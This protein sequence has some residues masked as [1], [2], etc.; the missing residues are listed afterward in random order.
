MTNYE[1]L[2]DTLREAFMLDKA[3]LDFG[4]Y[5]IM[6][7]KRKD[8]EQFLEKDL[9][10]Q[11]REIL[12]SNSAVDVVQLEREIQQEIDTA[13]KYGNPN[14]EQLPVVQELREKYEQANNMTE[15]ENEVFSLLSN[16]FKRYF[17]KGD[18]ISMR[19]Y[20]KDVYAIPYEG[21]EVKLHWANADQYYI[22]SSENFKIYRFK[23]SNGKSVVFELLEATTEQNNNKS[24]GDKERK[25]AI[26]AENPCEVVDEEFK[27]YFNYEPMDKKVKQDDL[28]K[29]A[30]SVVKDKIPAD[31]TELLSLRPTEKDKQRTLL[32]KNLTDYTA[33]NTFDYFIHKDLNGFLTR[34]L[35]FYIKNEVLF[36]D[37]INTRDEQA[38]VRQ[39]SKIKA[40]KNIG[41]K[42][43]TFLAQLEDFQKKLWLKKKMVVECNYCIT[44]DRVPEKFYIE[45]ANNQAQINEWISLFAIDEIKGSDSADMFSEK[46]VGFS[47]PLTT[48]FLKQNPFLVLDTAFFSSD[49]KWKLI[50]EI[51]DFDEKCDG[52]L[53]NS[54]NFHALNLLTNRYNCNL[55]GIYIDPPYNTDAS[56]IL[57]KNNYKDSSF[58][59]LIENRIVVAKK[60]LKDDGIICVAIDD[61]EVSPLRLILKNN[62]FAELGVVAVRS[63]PAGRKTKGRFAPAHEYALFYGMSEKSIPGSLDLTE[64]RLARYPKEDEKGRFSWA[65]FIRSGNNDKREDR[66]KLYY[67]IFANPELNKIRIPKIIWNNET[68]SYDLLEQPNLDEVIVYPIIR[69]NGIVVE[70]N[71]QRGSLRVPKELDEYRVRVDTTGG[72]NVDFKTRLDESSLPTTW[73][74]KKEYASANYGAAEMKELFLNKTFDFPKAKNLVEDCIKAINIDEN[75]IVMDFFGGSATTAESVINLNRQ[76]NSNRKYILVEVGEYFETI[77]SP[78]TK[79]II[80]SKDWKDGK[81]ISRVGISHCFKYFNLESYED[82]LNNLA[83]KQ[84]EV[85]QLAFDSNPKFKEGY[86]LNYMLDV[87]TKDSLLN[88]EWFADPFNCYLN[89]TKNNEMKPT[90]VDLVETFNYLIG[91]VVENYAAP[92]PG[93]VVITGKNLSGE[94][95]LVVWRDCNQ[96]DN[97]SLNDFLS[98]S[99]Y[100]PLDAEFDRIYVNGDNNVENL[101]VGDE[102]WKVVL[103]EEEFHKRM[104]EN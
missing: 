78:R 66:P 68:N 8:I 54:D 75:N 91:L 19:R 20:K 11:V 62:F 10:P 31:F 39:L 88:L 1:K 6:N 21:E 47:N 69:Q 49:F 48:E 23:L 77:T 16:F 5:R 86:M 98:R 44:L 34:E 13:K 74:D 90:K 67:P 60:L 61:E 46:K 30:F 104:F 26:V 70:K 50:S 76:D 24:Q 82:T 87:E 80:Y 27:I 103:I 2:I 15:L 99:K 29:E 89:I 43:I 73:W 92:K 100:N 57:Y 102:R 41:E 4:I 7:Q 35:D 32:Q 51:E 36:I 56:S 52:L 63:N 65:N 85:Q 79:K 22:K 59:S 3:E 64:K 9:I 96:H 33:K 55:S 40:T 53:I 84:D 58:L 45:I 97:Q 28:L 94:K 12:Q 71:W 95:I 14:P 93:Y 18:F 101:K 17:D 38:F 81:P 72:V 37:D 25:F 83:I 42:I